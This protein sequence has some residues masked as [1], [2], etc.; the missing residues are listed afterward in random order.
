MTEPEAYVQFTEDIAATQAIQCGRMACGRQINPGEPRHALG[1]QNPNGLRKIV[2]EACNSYYLSLPTTIRRK[3][4]SETG[5]ESAAADIRRSVNS[6][7]N[8]GASNSERRV[9]AVSSSQ[10]GSASTSRYSGLMPPPGYPRVTIPGSF[11]APAIFTPP[12]SQGGSH[13]Y[14]KGYSDAHAHYSDQ[15]EA[16]AKRAY[17]G[18]AGETIGIIMQVLHD[19]PGKFKKGGLVHNLSEGK[20]IPANSTPLYIIHVVMKYMRPLLLAATRGFQFNWDHLIVRDVVSWTNLAQ[21]DDTHPFYYDRCLVTSS[22]KSKDKVKVFKRPKTSFIVALVVPSDQWEEYVTYAATLEV[23]KEETPAAASSSSRTSTQTTRSSSRRT[24]GAQFNW[25]D[26]YDPQETGTSKRERSASLSA[27]TTPPP[28]KKRTPPEYVSPDRNKLWQALAIGGASDI[29]EA[30]TRA[31]SERVEF[32]QITECSLHELL[33]CETGGVQF[34]KCEAQNSAQGSLMIVFKNHIGVGTFKTAH[35]GHLSLIHLP[36]R[37]LGTSPNQRVAVKRLYRTRS[38]KTDSASWVVRRLSAA[39][40]YA[41]TLQEANLLFWA[42]SIM[43]FTYSFINHFTT[44]TDKELPFTIPDL[45]FVHA[46]VAVAHDQVTGTNIANTSTIRRTYIL[47]EFIDTAT[48]D[49]V[50]YIHN[51]DAAPHLQSEDPLYDIAQFLCFTQHVQYFKTGGAVFLSDL[52]GS[53]NLLTDPQIMTSPEIAKGT[54]I[55]G[56]GNVGE[57]FLKFPEQHVCNMYCKWFELPALK[58]SDDGA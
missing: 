4:R 1:N 56:E 47:E 28:S 3:D 57:I 12:G 6:A 20:S 49:F 38:Q 19:V 41:K 46:G 8:R 52:Q 53:H 25:D 48:D 30:S 55:F 36:S 11:G 13:S 9:T 22:S 58:V 35:A 33:H 45:R 18:G 27:P 34:F 32:F 14:P 23:E 43:S 21:E 39:D 16:W 7:R 42:A 5:I 26:D 54:D 17:A 44:S 10:A 24:H 2:C 37:G 31:T 51:G 40:E 50:K 29:A 15:R